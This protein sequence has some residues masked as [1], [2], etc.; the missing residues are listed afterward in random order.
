IA[1]WKLHSVQGRLIFRIAVREVE[2]WLLAD[3]AGFAE[4]LGLPVTKIPQAP[5]SLRDPKQTLINLAR[6]IKRR[7]L[8]E[9]LIPP[10]GSSSSVGPFYNDRLSEFVTTKWNVQSASKRSPS[11][12]KALYR[13]HELHGV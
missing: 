5:E 11:L 1:D 9:E 12:A 13:L 10:V 4:F 8:A 3:R 6:R 7:R 2:A